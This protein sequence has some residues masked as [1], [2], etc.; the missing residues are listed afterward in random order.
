MTVSLNDIL[1]FKAFK[2]TLKNVFMY[3][4][5]VDNVHKEV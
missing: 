4:R 5:P 3:S 1:K 2:E